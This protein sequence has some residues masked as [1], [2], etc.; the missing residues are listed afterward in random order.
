MQTTPFN[1]NTQLEAF[2]LLLALKEMG[3][4]YEI[5]NDTVNKYLCIKEV[6]GVIN[7]KDY[8]SWNVLLISVL[9]YYYSDIPCF[10]EN[11]DF[12]KKVIL[13][14]IKSVDKLQRNSSTEL[15]LLKMDVV[16]CPFLDVTYKRKVLALFSVND[17]STQDKIIN[18]SKQ[19]KSWFIKWKGFNLNYEI[20][21][22][23]SQEVYS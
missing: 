20:N 12:L 1:Q 6:N 21:A 8:T 5:S 23:V 10:Q 22:K 15:T 14:K 17:T 11:I 3:S 7:P 9:L 16:A 18:Y 4:D 13:E 2:Y 19:Q